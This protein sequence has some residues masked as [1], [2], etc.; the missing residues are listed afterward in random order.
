MTFDRLTTLRRLAEQHQIRRE[1]QAELAEIRAAGTPNG[2]NLIAR[3][4][5][6]RTAERWIVV[7]RDALYS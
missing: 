5:A 2:C 7:L 6:V 1:T 4:D 3:M